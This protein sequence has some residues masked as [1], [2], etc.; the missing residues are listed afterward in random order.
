MADTTG[1]T[2]NPGGIG[3]GA[4]GMDS[5]TQGQEG[6]GSVMDKAKDVAS[7]VVDRTKDLAS[8]VAETAQDAA[9]AVANKVEGMAATVS[10]TASCAA[11]KVG[12][13]WQAGSEYVQ[14]KAGDM[15]EEM[16]ILI[17]RHP[18][19]ALLVGFGIGFMLARVI[20]D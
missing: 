18:I 9:S 8:N 20:R 3:T 7:N 2:R 4:A 1:M 12:D 14:E 15:F 10:D 16:T 5:R 19:P 11:A 6:T 17:R 13:T